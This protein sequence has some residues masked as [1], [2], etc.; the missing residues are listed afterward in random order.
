MYGVV[1]GHCGTNPVH[2]GGVA[3]YSDTSLEHFGVVAAYCDISPV[4]VRW[5]GCSL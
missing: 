2:F 5:C 4:L 3:A 1:V